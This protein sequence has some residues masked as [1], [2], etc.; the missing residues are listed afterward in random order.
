MMNHTTQ[1]TTVNNNNHH[2]QQQQPQLVN[3]NL[4]NYLFEDRDVQRAGLFR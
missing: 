3:R 1:M 2:H 4:T